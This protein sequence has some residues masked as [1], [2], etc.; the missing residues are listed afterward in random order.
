MEDKQ[1]IDMYF[2][3]SEEAIAQTQIKYGGYCNTIAYNILQNAEDVEECLSDMLIKL[4]DLIPPERP[5]C[6]KAYIGKLMRN[7]ALNRVKYNNADKR[8]GGQTMAVIDEL[9]ECI[10][11]ANS[12]ESEIDKRQLTGMINTFLGT[13]TQEKRIIFVK[14]YWYMCNVKDIAEQEGMS[15]SKVKSML[16]R[17]RGELKDYLAGEGVIV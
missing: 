10:P 13:L 17:I 12:V 16:F 11:D 6:F 7:I 5:L 8:G 1:I 14:R 4:W 2:S 15:E 9:E 3:R